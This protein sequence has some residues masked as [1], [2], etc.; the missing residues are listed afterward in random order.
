MKKFALYFLFISIFI[1]NTFPIYGNSNKSS[2]KIDAK[3]A[4]VLNAKTGEVL[5]SKYMYRKKYPASLTKLMTVLLTLE[6]CSM[7]EKVK[8]S[9]NAIESIEPGSSNIGILP[10]E[11]L[12]IEQCLY[13]MMLESANEVCVAVAEHMSGS[14]EQFAKQMTQ[15]AKQLGC[16][17][18]HF[19]NPHGLHHD[20][21]YTTA[22]DMAL[23]LKELLKNPTFRK[24]SS[25]KNYQLSKTNKHPMRW[26]GNH[27]KMIRYGT[28]ASY[29][30]SP[31][32]TVTSGK[33]AFT[34]KAKT[35]LS[36]SATN[37][38]M[39]LICIVMDDAGM[40]VYWDTK[41]LLEYAFSNFHEV[42]PLPSYPSISPTQKNII[43]YNFFTLQPQINLPLQLPPNFT[44]TLPNSIS[45]SMVRFQAKEDINYKKNQYGIMDFFVKNKKVATAPILFTPF[46]NPLVKDTPS[47]IEE[48]LLTIF[49]IPFVHSILTNYQSYPTY[50]YIG[51]GTCISFIFYLRLIRKRHSLRIR[52]NKK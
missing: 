31:P 21:H 39:E 16:K 1:T 40:C 43:Q 33:T 9:K 51:L 47:F 36:T 15:R 14:Q 52:K 10:N 34:T 24:I 37:H 35:C 26:L 28:S 23:I 42:T 27:H 7:N 45:S 5:Y 12:T 8:F 38:S 49:D 17:N 6:N 19:M 4:I 41:T 29:S 44:I 46:S 22:Y 3:T 30:L 11:V 20:Q 48:K 32:L 2:P 50:Y 18:T 25:S 13:G